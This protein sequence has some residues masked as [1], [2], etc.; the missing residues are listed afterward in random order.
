MTDANKTIKGIS[1][2]AVASITTKGSYALAYIWIATL[3]GPGQMGAVTLGLAFYGVFG[4]FKDFGLTTAIISRPDITNGF[5]SMANYTRII[6]SGALLAICVVSSAFL[7]TLFDIPELKEMMLLIGAA[8]FVDA[9]GFLSYAMLHRNLEFKKIARVDI[10]ASMV[11]AVTVVV[12][13]V[14]G[15]PI[16]AILIAF[17]VSSAVK[18]LVLLLFYPPKT[19]PGRIAFADRKLMYFGAKL[20]SAGVVVYIWFNMNVFVLGRIDI[21]TLGFYGLAYLWANTPADISSA[22]ISRV[23]LPTYSALMRDGKAVFA[24]YMQTLRFLFV[25][26]FGAFV[27][28]VV[29]SP[30]LVMALFGSSWEPAIPILTV[31]LVFGLGRTLLEPAGSLILSLQRPGVILWTNVINLFL[32]SALVVPMAESYGAL[33]CAV[34]LTTVYLVNICILWFVVFRIFQQNF[35]TMII[36]IAR[37]LIA[38]LAA[39][40]IGGAI[41]FVASGT[42]WTLAAILVVTS[43]Y[44]SFMYLAARNDLVQTLR[45]AAHA[46]GLR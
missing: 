18:T 38:A 46:V 21:D 12:A 39:L 26:S 29:A 24:G 37:P 20:V 13:S 35:K 41:L 2:S 15:P 5:I 32:V 31:L 10:A 42:F 3:V 43:A 19:N 9:L 30:I 45:Y 6:V 22:T 1:I 8:L 44:V 27:F 23:M 16:L 17:V 36:A 34:L 11:L 7:P 40:G 14:L 28:L 25:A 4:L 33:G